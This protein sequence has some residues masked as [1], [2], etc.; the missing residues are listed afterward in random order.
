VTRTILIEPRFNG[1]PHTA[2]GG[3]ACG[4]IADAVG[5]SVTVRLQRPIPL[6]T[7]LK[8][9]ANSDRDWHVQ[10]DEQLLAVVTRANVYAHV[11]PP[12]SYIDALAASK[13]Y[14]GFA[15]HAFPTCFVCGPRRDMGDGL[16]IFPGSVSGTQLVAAPWLPRADLADDS[17]KVRPEFIWA[18]LDCP[19]YFASI[20]E[21]RVAL[22]GELTVHIDR[23]VHAEEPCVVIGWRI[24]IEGRKHKVGTAL[25]DGEGERCALGVATWLEA[26]ESQT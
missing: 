15:A 26:K 16:R 24:L 20:V 7:A 10:I 9:E 13:H 2:N 21:N 4:L 17:G 3:Y 11:P 12:P 18:A 8:V 6:G 23:R 25:F 19:G 14:A 5:D 22:L 1:P